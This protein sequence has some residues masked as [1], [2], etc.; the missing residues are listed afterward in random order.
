MQKRKCELVKLGDQWR[1]QLQTIPEYK[2][3]DDLSWW[4]TGSGEYEKMMNDVPQLAN[5]PNQV[6]WDNYMDD[7]SSVGGDIEGPTE[8]DAGL[9]EG[10]E[11]LEGN[12]YGEVV[13]GMVDMWFEGDE[14][15]N[16]ATN[17]DSHKRR[18]FV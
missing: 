16:T 13:E 1:S 5:V 17:G 8:E 4:P 12:D 10:I 15:E 9:T 14:I 6:N 18:K 11:G 7:T 2:D 3:N